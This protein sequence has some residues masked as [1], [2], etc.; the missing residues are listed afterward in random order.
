MN[1]YRVAVSRCELA[2]KIPPGS[3]LW[4]DFNGSFDNLDVTAGELGSY[5]AAGHAFTTWH[6]NHWRATDNYEAGQH[7]GLDFD[8]GDNTSTL[9]SL[10]QNKFVAKYAAFLYTTPSH[11]AE[12]PRARAVFLLDTPIM[13]PANYTLAASALLWLFGTADRQCKDAVRFFYGSQD[14][15]MT[16][17][18]NVLPLATVR[19]MIAQYQETGHAERKRMQRAD[20]QAPLDQAEVAD[21]LRSIDPWRL[22]YGEWVQVLMAL[23]AA[24][25]D[26]GR[27]LADTWA[28]G[29]PGEVDRKWRTFKPNGNA[30]GA[31]TIATVFGFAKRA[32]WTKPLAV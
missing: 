13:Q 32:G 27:V 14:C 26:G 8:A 5:I 3:P 1:T 4:H 17:L 20:W 22:D 25:G 24:F 7:L 29:Q 12:F 18:D 28:D 6:R 30:A 15:T 16:W 21:A 2:G 31:V 23:H 9:T 19:H 10:A 11:T